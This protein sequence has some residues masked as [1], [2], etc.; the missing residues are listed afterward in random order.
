[1]NVILVGTCPACRGP[2]VKRVIAL[3]CGPMEL[4]LTGV[5]FCLD[6]GR[7]EEQSTSRDIGQF[8]PFVKLS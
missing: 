1:M 8:G 2:I 7:E 6:C 3:P 5:A 4:Q